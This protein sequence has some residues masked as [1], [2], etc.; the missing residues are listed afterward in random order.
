MTWVGLDNFQRLMTD[1]VFWQACYNTFYLLLV[2]VP[3]MTLLA[4]V[5]AY[6]FNNPIL[7][8]RKTFQLI[9][10]LP[11]VT[12]G[13]AV[14]I[15]FSILL[16]DTSG[17]I[18]QLI[19]QFGIQPI[20]WLRSEM[21]SK[22]SVNILIIWQWVGY[23]MMIMIGGLQGISPEL[24]EAAYIDGSSR[25]KNFFF[26]TIPLLKP[27]ILF[28]TIMSTIGTF[29]TFVQPYMLTKGGPGYSSTTL[30]LYQYQ[31]TFK[32]FQLGYG[33]ALAFAILAFTIIISIPQIYQ[34]IK[35]NQ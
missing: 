35:N 7:K 21:W 3:T 9:S 4:L 17:L 12:S 24:Y 10:L 33:A 16:D 18:N 32:Y 20:P 6:V 22:M 5:L 25:V 31:Q 14:A 34:S 15:V 2:N 30:T 8:F 26:I 13:V 11:Y 19:I 27:V 28:A 23:N 29:N 1:E